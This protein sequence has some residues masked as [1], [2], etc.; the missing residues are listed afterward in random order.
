MVDD[1]IDR[2]QRID[3]LGVAA[4]LAHGV[5]H[6]GEVDHGR[7]AGEVLHQHARRAEVD[8]LVRL[9]AVLQPVGEGGDVGLL[10]RACRPR[11]AAGFPAARAARRAGGVR[12]P[13]CLLDRLEAEIGV[14]P[15]A[16]LQ[17]LAGLEAVG[18]GGGHDDTPDGRSRAG[19][20]QNRGRARRRQSADAGAGPLCQIALMQ[21]KMA[22]ILAAFALLV[23]VS[24]EAS[25]QRNAG[26]SLG[27]L[28]ARVRPPAGRARP[29]VRRRAI[30]PSRR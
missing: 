16:D 15:A 3:L 25:A 8:L 14:A 2:H 23:T 19:G 1:E 13:T 22:R 4:Q 6:G 17:R 29:A 20:W 24:G 7:H 11:G 18:M 5:A 21:R 28:G 27:P 10:D 26:R 30:R 12:S 9:A